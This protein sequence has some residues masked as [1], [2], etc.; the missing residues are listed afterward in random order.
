MGTLFNPGPFWIVAGG[1]A[2]C[3]GWVMLCRAVGRRISFSARQAHAEAVAEITPASG[4]ARVPQPWHPSQGA[5]RPEPVTELFTLC[6]DEPDAT[7]V[8]SRVPRQ[9]AVRRG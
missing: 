5:P 7:V 1:A 8:M 6:A 9:R 4:V 3:V 2:V